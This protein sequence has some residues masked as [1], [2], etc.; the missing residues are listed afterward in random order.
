MWSWSTSRHR[1]SGRRRLYDERFLE[2]VEL[3]NERCFYD[4]HEALEDLWL[5]S[6][7]ENRFFYQGLIHLAAAFHHLARRNMEGFETRLRSAR[8]HLSGYPE[9][10]EGIDLRLVRGSI[11]VWLERLA[12]REAGKALPYDEEQ[13]PVLKLELEGPG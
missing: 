4:S 7:G 12:A 1:T 5:D 9:L 6:H 13:V 11:A 8:A 3:F 2:Y 10:Y